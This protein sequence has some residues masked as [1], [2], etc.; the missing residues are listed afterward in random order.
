M[1]SL[2]LWFRS[3][4][5]WVLSVD[6]P[7]YPYESWRDLPKEQWPKG[8]DPITDTIGRTKAMLA[9]ELQLPTATLAEPKHRLAGT[10][11]HAVARFRK[12]MARKLRKPQVFAHQ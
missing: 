9:V 12:H 11:R 5:S 6:T 10:R 7:P 4:F 1:N 8:Y 3:F 2:T